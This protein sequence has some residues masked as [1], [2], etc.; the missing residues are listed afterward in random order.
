MEDCLLNTPKTS[1][2]HKQFSIWM[3]F[4]KLILLFSSSMRL[5]LNRQLY[6][7]DPVEETNNQL[8]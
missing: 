5:T 8:S 2:C 6:R 3:A 1:M 7:E 4:Y